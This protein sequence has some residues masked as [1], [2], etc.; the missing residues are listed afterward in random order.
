MGVPAFFRWLSRKYKSLIVHAHEEKEKEVN[1]IKVPINTSL[2]NPNNMEFDN[3][4]LDMNGIIH[5]CCH[6]ED[7]PAPKNENEMMIAIF[8]MLDRLFNIVRPRKILYMAIDG[9]APRAKMN[10]Q[11]SRRF[12]SAKEAEEKVEMLSEMR[13]RLKAQGCILPPEKEKGERFDSNCITP[14]TEFMFRLAECLRYYCFQRLNN[15][16]G[17]ANIQ[18]YLSDSNVPGE[19]EHKIMDFIRR[20][21]QS[22]HYEPDTHHCLCGA[23]AD[24]IML[25]LAT[26]EPHFTIIREEFKPGP[27]PSRPCELCGQEGHDL[28][29]CRGLAKEEDHVEGVGAKVTMEQQYIF[30]RLCVLREYLED[31]LSTLKNVLHGNYCLERAI[32]DWVFLC[33]FV[34]NDFLAHLP[35]LE[36]REGAIDRLCRLYKDTV[37]K[38]RGYLCKDGFPDLRKVQI[39]MTELGKMEDEIFKARYEKEQMFRKRDKD[40]KKREKMKTPHWTPNRP[41][42]AANGA[43]SGLY[44]QFSEPVALGGDKKNPWEDKKKLESNNGAGKTSAVAS[45]IKQAREESGEKSGGSEEVGKKRPAGEEEEEEDK[46]PADDVRL[47]EDGWRDRYYLQKFK[48]SP[49]DTTFVKK[50]VA[51]YVTGLCWVLRYYYQGCASWNWYFPFHYA[52]FASDFRH[53]TDMFKDFPLDTKPFNPMEQLMGVFPAGSKK[54]L[55][56]EWAELMY[57]PDSQIIDFYPSDFKIDLNGKKYAW[58]GVA[59]LPF[60]D[61]TRLLGALDTVY[62][63]LDPREIKRNKP[64]QDRIFISSKHPW[65]ESFKALYEYPDKTEYVELDPTQGRGTTGNVRPDDEAILPGQTVRSPVPALAPFEN[66]GAISA[67][68]QNPQ[69]VKGFVFPAKLLPNVKLPEKSLKPKD[70]NDNRRGSYRPYTG[71]QRARP[72][73]GPNTVGNRMLGHMVRGFRPPQDRPRYPPPG[74]RHP[75]PH[76]QPYRHQNRNQNNYN[77][78][79]R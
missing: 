68:Y 2:P 6:P 4:Y 36:I 33:F 10:Q 58:Q 56:D 3:L 70:W 34:G 40:R 20:Q 11:R 5:P 63:T 30:V 38:T 44:K 51:A 21:R 59:L 48:V 25:G 43:V 9:V 16:P 47:H 42:T 41:S 1:G 24:L 22:P 66:T 14:G 28:E 17:W 26:H 57:Q 72:M 23:D 65:Y 32:D 46:E 61:E 78:Y 45:Y 69:F 62:D 54:F 49:E 75:A 12:R 8:D 15:D 73:Q 37:D 31:E 7:R 52:P 29:M 35:S 71:F 67:G 39:I 60:V 18:V 77:P 79:R 64:G 55:P 50:V 74:Q 19:G 13:T 76:R 27:P 53:I